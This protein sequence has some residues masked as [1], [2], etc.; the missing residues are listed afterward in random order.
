MLVWTASRTTRQ[1]QRRLG[2]PA[3]AEL[4]G[5]RDGDVI[6]LAALTA[7]AALAGGLAA[8]EAQAV[9]QEPEPR[10]VGGTPAVAGE[11][12]WQAAMIFQGDQYCGGTVIAPQ[13]V[14]TAHHCR[15]VVSETVRVGSINSGVGGELRTVDD[16]RRHPLA[17]DAGTPRFDVAVAHLNAPLPASAVIG[18]IVSPERQASWDSTSLFTASGWGATN[19]GER[20]TDVLLRWVFLPWASDAT[21]AAT[22]PGRFSSDDMVCAGAPGGG[23]DTCQGDSGGPMVTP[24]QGLPSP[25]RTDAGD[26]ELVGVTSWGIG[27]GR[28][29]IPGV[30]ARV[31]APAIRDWLGVTPPVASG[32]TV[33]RGQ[34]T[35]DQEL[36]CDPG[37]SGGSAYRTY[38]FWRSSP[39]GEE[40]L[41]AE[42]TS[43]T[44]RLTSGDV[45]NRLSCDGTADNAAAT[46]DAPRSP[47][48]DV[49]AAPP[50][51][52]P[53]VQATAPSVS[54]EPPR[55]LVER[56]RRRCTRGRRC[57][58]T[59]IPSATTTAIRATLR[60]TVRRRCG[61][62]T[63]SR[64]I[65]RRLRVRRRGG[66]FAIGATRLARGRHVLILVAIDATGRASRPAYRLRFSLT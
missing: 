52:P 38:R 50:P 21:C 58:F 63:C 15:V 36:T 48:V 37:W 47:V 60:S 20:P 32:T 27:C 1:L 46:T 24:V 10:I 53:P 25:D 66:R 16:V 56:A 34:P 64:T 45:G 5:D 33:L 22:Y 59:I 8:S 6:R 7:I 29:G 49:T 28:P 30:Y 44:Y 61:R 43:A 42:G 26:W 4:D 55:P 35:F 9:Q 57:T 11:L 19:E 54:A 14:L 51:P 23:V 17:S 40:V 18:G 31:G 3:D 65:S 62:R 12:P 41:V 13:Y 39:S 2:R